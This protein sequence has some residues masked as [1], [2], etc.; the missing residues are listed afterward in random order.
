MCFSA[1]ASFAA[2][3]VC[4]A[5][6]VATLRRAR[7]NEI[8]IS[9]IPLIFSLH[10]AVE[11]SVWLSK[12]QSCSMFGGYIYAAIAFCLWST[13]IPVAAWLAEDD[14]T[15]RTWIARLLFI[16]VPLSAYNFWVLSHPLSIDF[17]TH[18]I[19]YIP[20]VQ[21]APA[22][23]IVYALPVVLPFLLMRNRVFISLGIVISIFFGLSMLVFFLARYS[24]WCFFAAI[25]STMILLGVNRPRRSVPGMDGREQP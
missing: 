3:A 14:P 10:Q 13:Y 5:V 9:L 17:S 23:E 22:L 6:G 1:E 25:S 16:G 7:K 18:Q 2:S 15:R 20:G 4:A 24:V 8:P 12:D 19:R 21:T 11:G